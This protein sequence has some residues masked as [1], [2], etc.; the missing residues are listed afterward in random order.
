[1]L[2]SSA[3]RR[4]PSWSAVFGDSDGTKCEPP[5]GVIARMARRLGVEPHV[6][7]GYFNYASM[8]D[9]KEEIKRI[10]RWY[11]VGRKLAKPPRGSCRRIRRVLLPKQNRRQTGRVCAARC[12][13]T[14][15]VQLY[16]CRQEQ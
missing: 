12:V 13:M 8:S 11:A 6:D 2:Q 4:H 10:M 3:V 16:R 14:A 15:K 7:A 1:M 5:R 9:F